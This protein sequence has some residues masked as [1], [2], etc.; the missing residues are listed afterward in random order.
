MN[1]TICGHERE[2]LRWALKTKALL[3]TGW[4]P[5][6]MGGRISP[7]ESYNEALTA[8]G[9]PDKLAEIVAELLRICTRAD[10]IVFS[11]SSNGIIT[12]RTP[13][14]LD[15]VVYWDRDHGGTILVKSPCSPDDPD[16]SKLLTMQQARSFAQ[17]LLDGMTASDIANMIGP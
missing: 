6:T 16:T 8:I 7:N 4:R 15:Y 14:R 9:K 13:S 3:E 17:A 12:G 10:V 1:D 2:S 5:F 11:P